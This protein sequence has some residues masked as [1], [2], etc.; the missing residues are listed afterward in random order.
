MAL[1]V[2]A[3]LS[4]KGF[5]KPI[6]LD[7]SSSG[8]TAFFGPSGSGKTSL[9]RV[10]SGL[11]RH[12]QTSV[13]FNDATWQ[14]EEIFVPTYQRRLAYVFQEPSLFAHL[15]VDGNLEFALSR[16]IKSTHT[17]AIDKGAICEVL[18][19]TRLL[20]RHPQTLSGGEAQR[21]A[22]ARALCSN[23]QL[24]LMDEPLSALG[25]AHKSEIIPLFEQVCHKAQIPIVYVSHSIDEVARFADHMVILNDGC[26]TA[27]GSI[28]AMLS[29]LD[30]PHAQELDSISLMLGEVIEHDVE[31]GLTKI[32]T[33]AGALTILQAQHLS[34][35]DKVKIKIATKDVS[36]SLTEAD[37][38]SILNRFPATVS[39]IRELDVAR[40]LIKLDAAGQPLLAQI[41]RKSASL[42]KVSIGQSLIAQV[43]SCALV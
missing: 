9:L 6:D 23:P 40:V 2:R 12:I 11:D 42:L 14:N 17:H 36:L 43:K 38:T 35:G 41:T 25:S 7:I 24:L 19:I 33:S 34:I 5:G 16:S 22:I 18:D 21:V 30:L 13:S 20:T 26:V 8:V 1:K 28:E 37:D 10:I 29:R 3:N 4:N 27:Q 15:T 32:S 31:F 39:E